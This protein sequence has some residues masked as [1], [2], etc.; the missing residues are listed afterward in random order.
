MKSYRML[1]FC[2][3]NLSML[4]EADEITLK[5]GN[6]IS[7]RILSV[8]ESIIV[9]DTNYG[10]LNII[11]ADVS[12]AIIEDNSAIAT[13]QQVLNKS[14]VAIIDDRFNDM[15]SKSRWK[16][17]SSIFGDGR[18]QMREGALRVTRG[19]N[20]YGWAEAT[21]PFNSSS[22][23]ITF[24]AKGLTSDPFDRGVLYILDSSRKELFA[25]EPEN[26][27]DWIRLYAYEYDATGKGSS[28]TV[29]EASYLEDDS[30]HTFVLQKIDNE[31]IVFVDGKKRASGTY[32]GQSS[33]SI[34]S[35][36]RVFGRGSGHGSGLDYSS[37]NVKEYR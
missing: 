15:V 5:N 1:L 16:D 27:R 36:I 30:E 17:I 6:K 34:P 21:I 31:Y 2:L 35:F 9:I 20:H 37:I 25:L 22:Y 32:T 23:E 7:G 24:T 13:I 10:K 28:I 12:Q 33:K 3:I 14:W 11:R 8:N 4:V 18:M 29:C 26:Y 19:N